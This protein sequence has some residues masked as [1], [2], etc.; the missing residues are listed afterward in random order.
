MLL[1]CS[2]RGLSL[3]GVC[4]VCEKCDFKSVSDSVFD[5]DS[6]GVGRVALRQS[7]V[8]V[9]ATRKCFFLKVS[10]ENGLGACFRRFGV[11][12]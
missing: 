8:G 5:A 9:T 11:E 10:R 6:N 3:K 4:E 2:G 7:E 12:W 1:S